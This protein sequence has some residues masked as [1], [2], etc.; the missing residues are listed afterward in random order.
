MTDFI[1][2]YGGYVLSVFGITGI[3]L[4]GR[5]N[6][7]GWL[8]SLCSQAAWATYIIATDQWPLI[9]GTCAYAVVYAHNFTKWRR[10]AN[11]PAGPT[12]G[13]LLEILDL[14]T[15][16][17]PCVIDKWGDCTAHGWEEDTAL[18]K[19]PHGRG[20]AILTATGHRQEN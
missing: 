10:D 5:K 13:E 1:T 4:A 20:H 7:F 14:I 6:A 2:H 15:F 8:I 17:E 16:G 9:Y 11:K 19:C 12:V 3:L 18:N